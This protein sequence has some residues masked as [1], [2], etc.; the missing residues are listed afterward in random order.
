MQ[1]VRFDWCRIQTAVVEEELKLSTV[2]QVETFNDCRIAWF[3]FP[4]AKVTVQVSFGVN[5]LVTDRLL[6]S[7]TYE[8]V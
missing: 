1:N 3:D 7:H 6:W 2:F 8:D 5:S 4:F